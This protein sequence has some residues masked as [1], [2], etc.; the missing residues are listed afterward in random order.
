MATAIHETRPRHLRRWLA[1]AGLAAL[2]LLAGTAG[3]IYGDLPGVG[4]AQA[5]VTQELAGHDARFVAIGRQERVAQAVVAIEDKRFFEHGAIDPIAIGRVITDT[6][7]GGSPDPGGSTIA[8]QLAKVL[9]HEPESLSGRLR[10]I[11]LAFK[12]EGSYSKPA[13]L[14][15]YLNAVYLGHDFYGVDKASHGYFGRSANRLTWAQASLLAGLPQAPSA[16]DPLRHLAAARARQREVL[17]QLVAQ[18]ALTAG[19]ARRISG[20]PLGLR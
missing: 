8:Q 17:A 16:F 10:A 12:L 18:H 2:G 11:G 6:L 14:S 1:A 9:Y 4:D 7:F 3:A 15:M 19:R 13:I 20:Q 5:R